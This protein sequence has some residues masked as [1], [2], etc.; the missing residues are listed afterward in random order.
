MDGL[1]TRHLFK[2]TLLEIPTWIVLIVIPVGSFVLALRYVVEIA[3]VSEA[4]ATGQPMI[5]RERGPT[6]D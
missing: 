3:L 2:P 6:I 4:I 5:K 1:Y